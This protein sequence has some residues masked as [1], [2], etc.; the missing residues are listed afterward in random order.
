MPYPTARTDT[1]RRILLQAVKEGATYGQAAKHAGIN[2]RTFFEWRA[3]DPEFA[4]EIRQA[5]EQAGQDKIRRRP[6][7]ARTMEVRETLLKALKLGVPNATACKAAGIA[8]ATFY[9]WVLDDE[10]FK[11]AVNQ[12]RAGGEIELIGAVYRAGQRGDWRAAWALLQARDPVAYGNRVMVGTAEIRAELE[13]ALGL[14]SGDGDG[15]IQDAVIVEDV[16]VV[17]DEV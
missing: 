6:Q 11:D 5:Y 17:E 7:P 3:E 15:D 4:E 2:E 12:A 14:G 16:E 9:A 8:P 13:S 1:N 10:E